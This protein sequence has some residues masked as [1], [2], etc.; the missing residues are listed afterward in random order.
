MRATL[1]RVFRDWNGC[2]PLRQAFAVNKKGLFLM[3]LAALGE[4]FSRDYTGL[5]VW[6]EFRHLGIE[7]F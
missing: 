1:K 4:F 6:Q 3:N 2:S 5:G 7:D